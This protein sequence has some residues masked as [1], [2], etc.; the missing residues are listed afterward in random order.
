MDETRLLNVL[1]NIPRDILLH[2]AEQ[3]LQQKIKNKN[4][5]I[6]EVKNKTKLEPILKKMSSGSKNVMLAHVYDPDKL[7]NMMELEPNGMEK[8]WN[9]ELEKYTLCQIF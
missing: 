1:S 3:L 8:R 9:L 2:C 5:L 6:T 7:L 4:T